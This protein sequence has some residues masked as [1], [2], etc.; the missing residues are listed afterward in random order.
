MNQLAAR[1]GL[2]SLLLNL[3]LSTSAQAHKRWLLPTDFALSDAETVTVDLSASNNIFYVDKA[4][5]LQ[6]LRALSPAGEQLPTTNPYHG[7]RRSSVDVEIAQAGTHRVVLQGAPVYF[8]SYE[9]PGEDKPHYARGALEK[10]KASVPANAQE[11]S[12]ARSTALIE[13]YISL[14]NT[15]A[16][17]ALTDLTGL[18]LQMVS[19]PNELYSDDAA[20]FVLLL[21]G[22]PAAGKSLTVTPEGTRYRDSQQEAVFTADKAGQVQVQWQGPGRY[23]VEAT[24]EEPGYGKDFAVEYYNYFLTVEVLA[25]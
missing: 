25:P 8:M 11:V 24:V 22:K 9:L 6:G 10:L 5:P 17:P 20:D 14:G 15:S 2:L 7:K 16:P 19:H 12:Y 18:S 13:T 21:N 4:L 3:T 1:L 23:L